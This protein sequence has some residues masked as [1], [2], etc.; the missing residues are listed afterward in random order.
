MS[1]VSRVLIASVA[2]AALLAPSALGA[3]RAGSSV[4]SFGENGFATQ[5]FGTEPIAGGAKESASMPDG[6]FLVRT[7][8]GSVGR[9]L[10]DGSLD[11]AFGEDGYLLRLGVQAMATTADGRIYLL[12]GSGSDPR[13]LWRLLPNGSPDPG[14][15]VGGMVRF[16][17]GRSFDAVVPVASGGVFVAGGIVVEDGEQTSAH[18]GLEVLALNPDG[19]PRQGFAAGGYLTVPTP[20]VSLELEPCFAIEGE[21]LIFALRGYSKQPLI[22]GRIRNDG[23]LDPSLEGRLSEKVDFGNVVGLELPSAGGFLLADGDGRVLKLAP[24]GGPDLGFGKEGIVTVEALKSTGPI[25]AFALGSEGN[26]YFATSTYDREEVPSHL[27]IGSL[28]K[29]GT[30][31][32]GFGAGSGALTIDAG[33]HDSAADLTVLAGGSLLFTGSS[34]HRPAEFIAAARFLPGGASD[35][36]FASGGL[37][38]AQPLGFSE[39]VVAGL[40]P[41]PGGRLMVVGR[42]QG[43]ALVAAYGRGGHPDAGFGEGGRVSATDLG[44][45]PGSEAAALAPLGRERALVA[46]DDLGPRSEGEEEPGTATVLALRPDGGIDRSFGEDGALDVRGFSRIADLVR[47]A[48]GGYFAAGFSKRCRLR[49]ARFGPDG[50]LDR[51]FASPSLTE[52]ARN[53]R[54]GRVDLVP[55]RGGAA[56][57]A[58]LGS[59]MVFAIDADGSL[60]SGFRKVQGADPRQL[61]KDIGALAADR[62]GG[63]LVAGTVHARLGV[64]RVTP[65]GRVARRFGIHG[66]ALREIGRKVEVGGMRLD[67]AGGILVAGT[68][69]LCAEAPCSGTAPVVVRFDPEGRVDRTFGRAGVWLGARRG[70][71][72]DAMTLDGSRSVV[73]GGTLSRAGDRDLML[74]KVRR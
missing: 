74:A 49:V 27:V 40:L 70:A 36:A 65:G 1:L 26:L 14:F 6:G 28:L 57:A 3:A 8:R 73:L 16:G 47:T 58:I 56:F 59:Q 43:Q 46:I 50:E 7:E 19:S 54:R 60:D 72:V 29:D 25:K 66:S 10:A 55:R 21:D 37:L 68:A 17:A 18:E 31:N 35:S 34:N 41:R 39:D 24:D 61:P 32:P 15:G 53:C 48:D 45:G 9:Y 62:R 20:K 33:G 67:S 2:V 69:N 30:P 52:E 44:A 4:R 22:L 42:A 12:S 5:G 63:L 51:R 71:E 64:M 13:V 23:T 11:P 38:L